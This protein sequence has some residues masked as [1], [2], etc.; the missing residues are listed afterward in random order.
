MLKPRDTKTPFHLSLKQGINMY[1]KLHARTEFPKIGTPRHVAVG[2]QERNI[3]AKESCCFPAVPGTVGKD[4][5][6]LLCSLHSQTAPTPGLLPVGDS[7]PKKQGNTRPIYAV[8]SKPGFVMGRAELSPI[9]VNCCCAW[10]DRCISRLSQAGE[11]RGRACYLGNVRPW[12]VSA[13]MG[14]VRDRVPPAP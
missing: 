10:T 7:P 13:D 14:W 11:A 2:V 5:V 12:F 3:C 8:Y 9:T 1:L 4:L 6:D